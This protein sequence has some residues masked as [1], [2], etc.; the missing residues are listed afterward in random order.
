LFRRFFFILIILLG[1]VFTIPALAQDEPQPE[2]VYVVQDG[3]TLWG[4]ALRFGLT[5]DEL[6]Q[7][8]PLIN[9]NLLKAG[10]EVIIPGLAGISGRL[11]TLDLALGVSLRSLSRAY[12]VPQAT[13]SRLNRLVSPGQMYIGDQLILPVSTDELLPTWSQRSVLNPGQSLLELAV[14]ENTTPWSI[15][16]INHLSAPTQT[17]PGDILYMPVSEPDA[18]AIS[19]GALLPQISSASMNA[20]PLVQ[21]RTVVLR[22]AAPS[23]WEIQGELLDHPLSFFR[24]P[25]GDWVALQGVHAMTETGLYP[26]SLQVT[27]P[28]GSSWNF[29][30][31]VRVVSGDYFNDPD[32]I[33]DPATIDPQVTGP[34][35]EQWDALAAPVTAGKL[36]EGGFVS[37]VDRDFAECWT[38]YYGNRRS[39][40]GSGYLYFHTGLDF[41]GAVGNNIYAPAAGVVV[42]A[43]PLA[44]RGNATMI[45]HGWGVYS[46]YMHQ[47]EITVNVGDSVEPGQLIGLVG[48]TGRVSGPHLH[49]EIWVGGVQVD[50]LEWL[51][52][53]FP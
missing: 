8:N 27:L 38:S 23:D 42:F 40:N 39:Y 14:L 11:Q 50:P 22:L 36:W 32:L 6:L 53:V 2:P 29:S 28:G 46:A 1:W 51:Q 15:S 43:G 18:G 19:P 34:E 12:A 7:A 45:N 48:G 25:E 49:L 3:D 30:Q 31:A 52:S 21:G 24:L 33:V 20:S 47:S 5:M 37:P 17:Q 26:L 41:C 16:L 13:I 4:I 35:N 44:V 9:A 10:D